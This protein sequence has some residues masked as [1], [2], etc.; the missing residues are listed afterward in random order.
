MEGGFQVTQ[1]KHIWLF[2]HWTLLIAP[3]QKAWTLKDKQKGRRHRNTKCHWNSYCISCFFLSTLQY[4]SAWTRGDPIHRSGGWAQTEFGE[5]P[6]SSGSRSTK[7]GSQCSEGGETLLSFLS[8]SSR[9]AAAT[10]AA[11]GACC[12]K[13][14]K[15]GSLSLWLGSRGP[16]MAR[17]TVP[18][19]PR[20]PTTALDAGATVRSVWQSR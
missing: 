17:Q 3:G 7:V 6:S 14:W 2:L 8:A 4:P 11:V 1:S 18:F 13:T 16:E 5:K 9:R 20:P 12:T 19:L 15:E 10:V